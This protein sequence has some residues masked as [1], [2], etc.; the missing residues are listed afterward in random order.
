MQ[1]E[2][3]WKAS[4]GKGIKVA[5]VDSGVDPSTP[6]LRGQVLPGKDLTGADGGAHDD[7]DGHGTTMAELIAGTGN[8]G[9]LKGLAPG[10]KVV[11]FRTALSDLEGAEGS[12]A[13]KA[14]RA[15]A[16]SDA[17]VINMSFGSE[18]ISQ[19]LHSAIDYAVSK[20]KLLIAGTGNDGAGKNRPF[21][22]A[23]YPEVIG[24]GSVDA[25]GKVS[26]FSGYGN[27]VS[28]VAPGSDIPRW[29][30][31]NLKKYCDGD[32]GTSAATAIASASAALIWSKHPE[33]N[34][35]QVARVLVGTTDGVME[36][37]DPSKYVG[38]GA[39][40][41]R[42]NLL[43]GKGEPG[44]PKQP[45]FLDNGDFDTSKAAFSAAPAK[46]GSSDDGK[47]GSGKG[48]AGAD[49]AMAKSSSDDNSTLWTSLGIAA[50]V[51]VLGG[52]AFAFMRARRG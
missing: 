3:M 13:D 42:L 21:Y 41:P 19:K 29:C 9:G 39:V 14:V 33:W 17:Q 52:G 37:R 15:A 24:V 31:K 25:Q 7:Y 45:A 35:N 8:G 16:N 50:A 28:V 6:S 5:V 49:D 47:S 18:Y 1:A 30:D 44:N 27:H 32:G 10:A 40:R 34:A 23:G 11:P 46:G 2:D 20:G 12:T 4:T 26:N 51:I 36:K 48:D 38:Y 22:P 43:E